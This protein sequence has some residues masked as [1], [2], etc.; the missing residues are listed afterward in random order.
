MSVHRK[1]AGTRSPAY[2]LPL[3]KFNVAD[4]ELFRSYT[5]WPYFER[6]R[7]RG[8]GASVRRERLRPATGR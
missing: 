5:F 3:D 6:L 4:P 2:D 7:A 1:E 8:P